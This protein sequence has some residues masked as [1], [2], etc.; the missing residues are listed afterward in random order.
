MEPLENLL[1]E[2]RENQETEIQTQADIHYDP[3][4]K[5]EIEE[6]L[7]YLIPIQKQQKPRKKGSNVE[8]QIKKYE[9]KYSKSS[10][11]Q[12]KSYLQKNKDE[13]QNESFIIHKR[14]PKNY[15]QSTSKYQRR[16]TP[17]FKKFEA[18][19]FSKNGFGNQKSPEKSP[20]HCNNLPVDFGDF[21]EFPPLTP[22]TGCK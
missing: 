13:S 12:S 5:T 2:S 20:K 9:A 21:D 7:P 17:K 11:K 10:P 3:N 18:G 19:E 6:Q 14:S 4:Q 15:R 8:N 1:M 22:E 16:K